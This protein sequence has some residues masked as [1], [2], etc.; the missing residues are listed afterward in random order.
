[1]VCSGTAHEFGRAVFWRSKSPWKHKI[2]YVGRAGIGYDEL[3]DPN[4][5]VVAILE[6]AEMGF[7]GRLQHSVL[8]KALNCSWFW[9]LG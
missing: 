6:C 8:K 5:L 1:M 9:P 7:V 3:I 4:A 2:A